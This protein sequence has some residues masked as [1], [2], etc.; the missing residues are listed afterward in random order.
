MKVFETVTERT[1]SFEEV[2]DLG[3]LGK[4]IYYLKFSGSEKPVTIIIN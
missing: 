3:M 1:G 2:L 4:G